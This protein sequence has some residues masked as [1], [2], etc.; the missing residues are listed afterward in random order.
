[1]FDISPTEPP[2]AV[3]V[4]FPP[5]AV[6][7]VLFA[8]LDAEFDALFDALLEF[9]AEFDVLLLEFDGVVGGV[10][11]TQIKAMPSTTS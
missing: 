2:V 9:D 6:T 10:D 5:V 1:M 8:A 7:F 3:A 11:E 4:A